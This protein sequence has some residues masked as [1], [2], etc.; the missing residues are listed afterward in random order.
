MVNL[1]LGVGVGNIILYV[2]LGLLAVTL[3]L[4]LA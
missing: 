3:V 4:I 2:V 1:L